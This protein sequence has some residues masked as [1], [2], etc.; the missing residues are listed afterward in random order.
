V[1]ASPV[2]AKTVAIPA[3]V[4]RVPIAAETARVA[5]VVKATDAVAEIVPDGAVIA[6]A[7]AVETASTAPAKIIL[8]SASSLR[9][10]PPD[11][12]SRA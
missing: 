7:E 3:I 5:T 4:A 1:E 11:P 9:S 8:P 12:L 10:S 2:E 6:G